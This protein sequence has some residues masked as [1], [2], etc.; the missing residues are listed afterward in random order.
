MIRMDVCVCVSIYM[1]RDSGIDA[2]TEKRPCNTVSEYMCTIRCQQRNPRRCLDSELLQRRAHD[3]TTVGSNMC[4]VPC[5]QCD[6][7]RCLD[8]EL[9]TIAS[10]NTFT[11]QNTLTTQMHMR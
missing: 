11:Q 3:Y 6:S 4:T 10:G 5:Q 7:L 1:M 9:Q 8:S 2:D